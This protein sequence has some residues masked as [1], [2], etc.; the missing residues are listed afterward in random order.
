[1]G[2]KKYKEWGR[3]NCAKDADMDKD[4]CCNCCCHCDCGCGCKKE[5]PKKDEKE[6]YYED[7]KVVFVFNT[8]IDGDVSITDSFRDNFKDNFRDINDNFKIKDS[9][10]DAVIVKDILSHNAIE[11]L[12]RNCVD[13]M[14]DSAR[15]I[16]NEAFKNALNE[17]LNGINSDDNSTD[18][19]TEVSDNLNHNFSCN[20]DSFELPIANQVSKSSSCAK[21]EGGSTSTAS[22]DAD[23]MTDG[24]TAMSGIL[25]E[26]EI[27]VESAQDEE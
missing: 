23:I 18:N 19:S 12:S 21:S 8:C 20:K 16:L 2:Y 10:R 7:G 15:D 17:S 25:E 6:E 4:K 5:E 1:M 3:P 24:G 14:I 27:D 11:I 22:N 9:F 26:L 13:L